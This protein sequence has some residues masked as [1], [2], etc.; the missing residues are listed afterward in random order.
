VGENHRKTPELPRGRHGPSMACA[1]RRGS[2]EDPSDFEQ[3]PIINGGHIRLKRA[4]IKS[5]PGHLL[6]T[7]PSGA[8]G[9]STA[10]S[11]RIVISTHVNR[12]A[13]VR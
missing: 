3:V 10:C 8:I 4:G 5:L 1:H 13:A 9:R 2:K 7:S 6:I 12:G 11:A